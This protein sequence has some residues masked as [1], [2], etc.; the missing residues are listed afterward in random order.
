MSY[1]ESIFYT[2]PCVDKNPEKY[3]DNFCE[4]S[5]FYQKIASEKLRE[6][7]EIREQSLAQ[8]RDWIA[9][10]PHIKKCRTDTQ[11]LLRFLRNRKYAINSACEMLERSLVA[12]AI[13]PHWLTNLD[14]EDPE[15]EALVDTGYLFT[16][17]ERDSKGCT[18]IFN[19]TAQL[20]PTKFN[21]GHVA[22]IHNLINEVN[23]DRPEV[24]CGGFVL[25]YDLSGM[26][27]SQLSLVSLND[28]RILARYVTKAI[29]VRFHELHFLGTPGPTQTIVNFVLQLFSEKLKQRI[30]FHRTWD[31]LYAKVDKNL[32][33]KEFGGKTPK[34][35]CIAL[36]KEQCKKARGRMLKYD[37][38]EIELSKDSKYWQET[39]DAELESGAIG[40]F[41]MLTVD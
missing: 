6:S 18:I 32:L 20:D 37:E 5:E 23:F 24:Q 39:S 29:P 16:L 22:R 26:T 41:R 13:H 21:A 40:S 19:E 10:H 30:M 11:Y 35:E 8:L 3:E 4:L 33:P 2:V 12:K 34:A 1:D 7:D 9:K 25:V 27:M 15:L 36:F 28:I 31:E 38:L 17:P 14:I